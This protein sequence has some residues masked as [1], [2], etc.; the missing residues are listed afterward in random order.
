MH[1]VGVSLQVIF[2]NVKAVW[3]IKGIL[4]CLLFFYDVSHQL[5]N[6]DMEVLRGGL[7]GR[8]TQPRGLRAGGEPWLDISMTERLFLCPD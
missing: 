2:F 7:S 1:L 8:A 3:P 4:N 6:Q 5:G